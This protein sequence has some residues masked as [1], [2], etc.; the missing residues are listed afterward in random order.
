MAKKEKYTWKIGE[1][2]PPI[3]EHSTVKHALIADYVS[4]YIE[5]YMA[6]FHVRKLSLSI[7]DGFAGGGRYRDEITQAVVDGSPFLILEAIKT[8]EIKINVDRRKPRTID[9]EY[10]FIDKAKEHHEFL[11]DELSAS[12]YVEWL[13]TKIRLYRQSFESALPG[14]IERIQKRDN[15]Q[16]ALFI[17]DQYAYKDVPL[18][19]IRKIFSATKN[20]EVILTFG[21]DSL[22]G[23]LS[24]ADHSKKAMQNIGLDC[25]I[26]WNRLALFK[27]S[28]QWHAAIQE[29]L[30]NALK[31]AS[32]AKHITLF[33]IIPKKG[34][35]YWLVHLSQVYRARDVMMDLHWKHANTQCSFRHYLHDG[36]FDLGYNA[37]S[38]N[39]QSLLDFGQEFDFQ[40]ESRNRCIESLST[41]LPKL[42]YADKE[43][44]FASLISAIGSSTPASEIHIKSALQT[45]IDQKEIIVHTSKGGLRRSANSIRNEDIIQY[46]QRPLH[47]I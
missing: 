43:M 28:N 2:L 45:A 42:I 20:S 44:T 27:E 46:L 7:I 8:A 12:D 10:H 23:F 11:E 25:Y 38:S 35:S 34:W 24:D 32:G 31:A 3:D 22:Q 9:A 5:V 30:S 21:Y 13:N 36:I 1:D 37:A 39:Q 6:G 47:L 41:E 14:I 16:R 33:Y 4:R 17:L 19:L 18:Q 29:Q 40:E 15:A 26:D